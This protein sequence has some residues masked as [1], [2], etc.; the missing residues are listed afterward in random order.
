MGSVSKDSDGLRKLI[1]CLVEDI[2]LKQY[3]NLFKSSMKGKNYLTQAL[4]IEAKIN[5][6]LQ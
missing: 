3:R 1:K 4:K 2:Y 5:Q 6:L